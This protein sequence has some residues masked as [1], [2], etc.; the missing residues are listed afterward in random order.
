MIDMM[1]H[2][3]LVEDVILVLGVRIETVLLHEVMAL[4]VLAA[5]GLG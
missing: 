4:V 2:A 1:P 5:L 3:L